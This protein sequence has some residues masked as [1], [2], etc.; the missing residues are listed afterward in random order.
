MCRQI[1]SPEVL[2]DVFV[3][4]CDRMRRYEGVWHLEQQ[5]CF[6]EYVFLESRNREQLIRELKNS[7]CMR[8]ILADSSPLVSL[9]PEEEQFL[10]NLWGAGH[11]LEMSRG[12]IRDGQTFV[13]EGPLQGKE[14]LI[15]R[16]DR[17]KRMARIKIAPEKTWDKDFPELQV[18]LE[19]V[20]KS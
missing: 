16:I 14:Q 8:D 7:S 3:F 10:R 1:L 6:P 17:H 15:R 2:Q 5:L 13:T 11:H 4:T 12:Y 18:G 9:N 19:I 20:A